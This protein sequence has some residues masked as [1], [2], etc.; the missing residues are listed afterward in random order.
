MNYQYFTVDCSW[1]HS[2]SNKWGRKA[3]VAVP[4]GGSLPLAKATPFFASTA[5]RVESDDEDLPTIPFIDLIRNVNLLSPETFSTLKKYPSLQ[6]LY[7]QQLKEALETEWREACE[8]LEAPAPPSLIKSRSSGVEDGTHYAYYSFAEDWRLARVGIPNDVKLE[9]AIALI[10]SSHVFEYIGLVRGC[11]L[12]DPVVPFINLVRRVSSPSSKALSAL[13]ESSSLRS[14]YMQ[15][16][17][18]SQEKEWKEACKI[19][20]MTETKEVLTLR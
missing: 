10:E 3:R 8:E 13:K 2:L 9:H 11:D 6:R 17:K 16:L 5:K 19:L 14:L 20:G 4:D 15:Q 1:S 12:D 7:M 18:E